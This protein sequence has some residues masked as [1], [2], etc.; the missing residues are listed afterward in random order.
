MRK[1]LAILALSLA[2]VFAAQSAKADDMCSSVAGN[3]VTNCGFETGDFT[4]WSGTSLTDTFSYAGVGGPAGAYG[5]Y[6]GSYGA[7]LGSGSND[8][9]YQ[10]LNTV[11]GTTY[12]IQFAFDNEQDPDPTHGYPNDFSV[13]FGGTT[14]YSETNAP[15]DTE[16][17]LTFNVLATGSS[18][19]LTFTTENPASYWD[20]D[21]VSV[22]AVASPVPEPSSL[23]LFGTGIAGFAGAV[24][25]RFKR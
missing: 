13:T 4:G 12:T 22:A 20:L 1:S 16:T 19:A 3:L 24:R 14:V 18:T 7:Y 2:S 8:T 21:S 15:Q 11:A 25:R 5:P 6:S 17:L 9:L 10:T 23:M